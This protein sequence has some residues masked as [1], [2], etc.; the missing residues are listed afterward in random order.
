MFMGSFRLI[1]MLMI[2]LSFLGESSFCCWYDT[3]S[4]FLHRLVRYWSCLVS[5]VDPIGFL[6]FWAW[7]R[8]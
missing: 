7:T 8:F 5:F 3:F 1:V 4:P 2:G 6:L